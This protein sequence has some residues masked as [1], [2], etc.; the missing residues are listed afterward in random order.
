MKAFSPNAYGDQKKNWS[1]HN[2]PLNV[3][4]CHKIGDQ[5]FSITTQ[6]VID[7]IQLP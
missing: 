4:Y 6:M 5:K 2:W 3:F 7:K 1:P